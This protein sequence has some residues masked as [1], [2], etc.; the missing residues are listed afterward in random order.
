MNAIEKIIYS[1]GRLR[2]LYKKGVDWADAPL[3][4]DSSW[5]HPVLWGEGL[6]QN[7]KPRTSEEY[8]SYFTSWVYICASL[9][10]TTLASVP[11]RLYV[12][13]EKKGKK[14][15]LIQTKQV[16]NRRLKYLYSNNS[17]DQFLRKAEEVEE[18]TDHA[19]LDLMTNVN[20]FINA[21]DLWEITSLFLDLTGDAYWYLVKANIAGQEV[22]VQ[23]WP[24]P[25]QYI[26]PVPGESLEDFIKG[27]IYRRGNRE[28]EL[29][30]DE[31]I[32]FTYPNPKNQFKGFSCVQ[33]IADAVYVNMKMYEFEE[34][35]FEKKARV[36][37]VIEQSER[38][39][40]PSLKRFRE[41]WEQKY[42]GAANSGKT[43]ILPYGLKFNRDTMTPEELSFI[44]GRKL[45]REEIA[46]AFDVPIGALVSKDINRANAEVADYRHMKNGILPRLRRIEE[47][48]N[49][50]LLP[51][52]DERL[53]VAFD[54]PVPEDKEFQLKER[55]AYT[56]ANILKINE[57]RQELGKEPVAWGES[58]WFPMNLVP[59][60]DSKKILTEELVKRAK[61]KLREMLA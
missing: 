55:E 56:K 49:E 23:I 26:K 47:K 50:R 41:S 10:A 25:S 17:L 54:N 11:L 1:L 31:V 12:A 13:K 53:F 51:M 35:L 42:S 38:V 24:I 21:R 60:E 16:D 22:P 15:P 48:L 33:G 43:V 9:N 19:F 52:F 37:G 39:S 14:Y 34:A 4:A 32:R 40:E 44:E 57:V 45:M 7:K 59:V 29:S 36:G 61:E 6:L 8:I 18:V 30:R 28:V 3:N 27:Y 5:M 2:G 58:A 20:P 46:A